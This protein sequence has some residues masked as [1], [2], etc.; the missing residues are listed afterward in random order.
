MLSLASSDAEGF[1]IRLAVREVR[2]A[3]HVFVKDDGKSRVVFSRV[4]LADV[5]GVLLRLTN[6]TAIAVLLQS[7]EG[8]V[9]TYQNSKQSV[10][11]LSFSLLCD[12]AS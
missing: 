3:E 7:V 4:I 8:G 2:N 6:H 11:R 1:R 12:A 5:A 9:Q 10:Y